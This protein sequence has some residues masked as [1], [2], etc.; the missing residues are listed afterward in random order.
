MLIR[1]GTTDSNTLPPSPTTTPSG[2]VATVTSTPSYEA[3]HYHAPDERP[4]QTSINPSVYYFTPDDQ[5]FVNASLAVAT[6]L[7]PRDLS[8]AVKRHPH[9]K[10]ETALVAAISMTFPN[11]VECQMALEI[12]PDKIQ[13]YAWVL[14]GVRLETA[15]GLRYMCVGGAEVLPAPR[16]T[17]RKCRADT[18]PEIFGFE[19]SNAVQSSPTY[20]N[21]V[22][23][24][25]RDCTNSASMV[26]SQDAD[27]VAVLFLSLGI[28][29]GTEI[30][31]KLY[32]ETL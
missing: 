27:E 20:E 24:N 6:R 30:R 15:A 7:L 18:I 8:N 25:Y 13:H 14:F 28:Y 3:S 11:E 5:V 29:K 10:K 12:I 16:L 17:L 31:E 21:D 1:S 9:P 32:V 22:V 23:K 4:V 2:A 19:V 26:M